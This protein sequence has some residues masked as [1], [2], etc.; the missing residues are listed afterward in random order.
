[1]ANDRDVQRGAEAAPETETPQP[2]AGKAQS[3][4]QDE[5][6]KQN[7]NGAFGRI[8]DLFAYQSLAG[9]AATLGKAVQTALDAKNTP[10]KVLL[11]DD[12]NFLKSSALVAKVDAALAFHTGNLARSEQAIDDSL[13]SVGVTKTESKAVT[14]EAGEQAGEREATP[15]DFGGIL[16]N[17]ISLHD[18]LQPTIEYVSRD[19]NF[20]A[21]AV[22]SAV[23][24]ALVTPATKLK[25]FIPALRHIDPTSLPLLK[26]LQQAMAARETLERKLAEARGWIEGHPDSP[27][28]PVMEKA[29]NAGDDTAKAF[30][31]HL[32]ALLKIEPAVLE[33][34]LIHQA[35][36]DIGAT[37]LLA[38]KPVLAVSQTT[39]VRAFP[40]LNENKHFGASALAYTLTTKD[41]QVRAA[42]ITDAG[43]TE[44]DQPHP[45]NQWLAWL[46]GAVALLLALFLLFGACSLSVGGLKV[47]M[48]AVNPPVTATVAPTA[49]PTPAA[50]P[51]TTPTAKPGG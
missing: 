7:G 27:Q 30:D 46:L 47:L 39:H 10:S 49:T 50:I 48:T 12:W 3:P 8:T 22:R 11:L 25:A 23:A 43:K 31:A 33:Q 9:S 28:K 24:G 1:M 20:D 38:F 16:G 19:L 6:G 4:A 51:S 36:G 44:I 37:H 5:A 40:L 41:G 17:L 14:D 32:E 13:T 42:G 35:A 34:A 45:A 26:R 21:D 29:V 15:A 18:L 2:D